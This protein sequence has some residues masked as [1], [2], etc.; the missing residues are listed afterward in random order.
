MSDIKGFNERYK[1]GDL[2]WDMGRPDYNLVNAVTLL[3]I[4]PCKALDIGCGTG[5][6]VFWLKSQRFD[7]S[8]CDL[9]AAAINI[10]REKA[11][12]RKIDSKFHVID[13]IDE[14]LPE[15]DYYFIF[16]RGCFHTMNDEAER[17][18]FAKRVHNHL[19]HEGLWLSLIGN[20]DE[21]RGEHGPPKLSAREVVS[22]VEP[23]FEILSMKSGRFDSDLDDPARI[24]ICLMRKRG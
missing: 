12:A 2:P 1:T 7:A 10:A 9:S 13:V 22:A 11:E 14:D 18:I 17:V 4:E 21:P 8:G 20:A 16:D 23:Y 24:W 19:A 5:E 15:R 3:P 6:N